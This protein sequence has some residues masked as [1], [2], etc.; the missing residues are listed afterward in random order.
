[1]FFIPILSAILLY[2]ALFFSLSSFSGRYHRPLFSSSLPFPLCT[3]RASLREPIVPFGA[4]L[5]PLRRDLIPTKTPPNSPFHPENLIIMT[6][7]SPKICIYQKKCVPLHRKVRIGV[8][9]GRKRSASGGESGGIGC[10][11]I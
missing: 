7:P 3:F 9:D 4:F 5:C 8:P 10:P 1:M 11:F 6:F 2:Y